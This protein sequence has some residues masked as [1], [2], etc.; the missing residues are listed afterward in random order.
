MGALFNRIK[1]WV[2]SEDVV[3][4]DLNAEF[5]NFLTNFVPLMMDD[6]SVNVTQMQ[7][8]TDP[9]EVGSESKATTIAGE[10]ER[11]RFVL[12]E[13]KGTT[14]WYTSANTSL[15]ELINALGSGLVANRISSGK[16]SIN[17][18]S[19]AFLVPN[20]AAATVVLDATPTPFVYYV[21]GTQYTISADVSI[22]SLVPAPASS[23]TATVNEAALLLGADTKY[24]GEFGT[25][26]SVDAIGPEI[27]SLNGKLAAFK[28]VHAG[29][30]EYFLAHVDTTNSR[31]NRCM[32]GCFLDSSSVAVPAIAINDNDT[33]TLMKLTWIFAK[34]DLTLAVSYTNPR[35]A[36]DAPTS[37]A[38]GDYWFDLD[39]DT[40]KIF[41]STTWVSAGATLIG[42]CIQ[43]SANCVAA[44]AFDSFR[45]FSDINTARLSKESATEIRSSLISAEVGVYG[46]ILRW[47]D[48]YIR[49]NTST[50]FES[51]VTESANTLYYLYLTEI[52][53]PLISDK[54][55]HDRR[56]DLKGFYHPIESW[57]CVGQVWNDNSSN[58][59][60]PLCF[61]DATA[62]PIQI[63]SY[64]SGNNLNL[65]IVMPITGKLIRQDTTTAS[66]MPT[67]L[68]AVPH[69]SLQVVSGATLGHANATAENAYLYLILNTLG[70]TEL[71]VSST[72]YAEGR[73]VNTTA[74]TTGSDLATDLYTLIA[75]TGPSLTYAGRFVSNQTTAG[76]W[77]AALTRLVSGPEMFV[78]P[79][80][81]PVDQ[82]A[83]TS[84]DAVVTPLYQQR[85]PS[86]AKGH[87]SFVGTGTVNIASSYNVSGLVDNGTG[88]YTVSWGT[89][90]ST[91]NY[92]S[93]SSVNQPDR[94]SAYTVSINV[95]GTGSTQ[96]LTQAQSSG[97]VDL[98]II[99]LAVFGD[100]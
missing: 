52:G 68:P 12:N 29:N 21:N 59:T 31:L 15:N 63:Y 76:T 32:R 19:P 17:S 9:G 2:S 20:G 42:V 77:A 58:F 27:I 67:Y 48:D 34:T 82:E 7:V 73:R 100:Q 61:T 84:Q 8:Q 39:N 64:V 16:T 53:D 45:S 50:D 60:E 33:I 71:G 41:N 38:V 72:A 35:V 90:F 57:R 66:G 80:A 37:P 51:S 56:G 79:I 25:V 54:P 88:N 4:S 55:P 65:D 28:V 94:T 22:T 98:A 81:T 6:Y 43:D 46:G 36:K 3:Y 44:R 18:L 93:V 85:H 11:I 26:I 14:Y 49:W 70:N 87:I 1:V 74:M 75:R 40:W 95:N 47:S 91:T 89:D 10:L 83:G 5:D 30:T 62:C 97:A 24:Q 92:C 13:M 23:N 86:A 69:V 78:F 96:L 99:Y